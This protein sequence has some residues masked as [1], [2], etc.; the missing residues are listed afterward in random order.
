MEALR[1]VQQHVL[2]GAQLDGITEHI[3]AADDFLGQ[4]GLLAFD[5]KIS[6]GTDEEND[7]KAGQNTHF[8]ADAL[9][10]GELLEP[11]GRPFAGIEQPM[12]NYSATL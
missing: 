5:G 2:A 10:P 6:I 7:Q 8:G 1:G 11:H 9:I 4:V 12:Q 3:D